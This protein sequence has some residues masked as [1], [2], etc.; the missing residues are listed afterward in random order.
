MLNNDIIQGAR[1]LMEEDGSINRKSVLPPR[2]TSRAPIH[3]NNGG[4]NNVNYA[5]V[6]N[7]L[8]PMIENVI[9]E[10]ID[11]IVDA[12]IQKLLEVQKYTTLNENLV[13]KV[14]DSIFKGNINGISSIK[15]K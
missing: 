6:I 2:S 5:D 3:E 15:K 1:R 11:K 12:K 8:K 4:T 7:F 10:S 13:I 14:G 9:R